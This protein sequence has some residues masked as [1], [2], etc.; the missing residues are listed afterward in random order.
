MKFFLAVSIALVSGLAQAESQTEIPSKD[1]VMHEA[2]NGRWVE[3]RNETNDVTVDDLIAGAEKLGGLCH[4]LSV[5]KIVVCYYDND[6]SLAA[7]RALGKAQLPT[8]PG[9]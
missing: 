9:K 3:Y 8:V 2:P 6:R 5:E 4:E 7:Y 1:T